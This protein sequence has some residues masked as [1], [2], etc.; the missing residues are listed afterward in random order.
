[1]SGQTALAGTCRTVAWVSSMY[2][3][4]VDEYSITIMN[5]LAAKRDK[6][7]AALPTTDYHLPTHLPIVLHHPQ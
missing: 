5:K 4:Q 7:T 3:Y 6:A 1:M 2:I